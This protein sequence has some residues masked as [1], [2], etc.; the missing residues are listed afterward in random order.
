MSDEKIKSLTPE[1][2][3]LLPVYR[4]KYIALGL[5]T[6]RVPE[7]DVWKAIRKLHECANEKFSGKLIIVDS[8]MEAQT[9]ARLFDNHEQNFDKMYKNIAA[10]GWY[11]VRDQYAK[12]IAGDGDNYFKMVWGSFE[13]SWLSYYAYFKEVVKVEGLEILDGLMECT[14]LGGAICFAELTIAC[15]RPKEINLDDQ[16]LHNATGPAVEYF[17]GRKS[18]VVHGVKVPEQVVMDIHAY[19]TAEILQEPNVEIRR[20]MMDFYG[21]ELLLKESNAKLV[22]EDEDAAGNMMKLMLLEIPE[23]E[24]INMLFV[25]DPA[26]GKLKAGILPQTGLRIPPDISNVHKAKA[27]TFS[28]DTDEFQP[29]VEV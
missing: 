18:F 9:I 10:N 21:Y 11:N 26:K 3:A 29:D 7:A 2:E 27:W 6:G 17:D 13:I 28:M 1:Q 23:D 8:P 4:D 12:E 14:I 24:D 22:H 25:H 16:G 5:K 20:I 19:S 15:Y